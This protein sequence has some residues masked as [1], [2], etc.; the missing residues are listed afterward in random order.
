MAV[1]TMGRKNLLEDPTVLDQ[2]S[3]EL[4]RFDRSR[5]AIEKRLRE[6]GGEPEQHFRHVVQWMRAVIAKKAPELLDAQEE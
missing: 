3:E 6:L 5:R 2:T 1:R 4:I